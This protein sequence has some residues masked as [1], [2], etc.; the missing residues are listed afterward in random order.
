MPRR[1]FFALI[2]VVVK[3]YFL[4]VFS[5]GFVAGT[6]FA[7]HHNYVLSI[8]IFV[9]QLILL[10]LKRF[11]VI[12]VIVFMCAFAFG[13][14]RFEQVNVQS[15]IH[16]WANKK[17]TVRGMIYAE[18]DVGLDKTRV[19]V[20]I[21]EI[22]L[23][24]EK[25]FPKENILIS[26]GKYSDYRIGDIIE[27]TAKLALPENFENDNG[28]E[29]DYVNFLGKEKIFTVMHQASSHLV[30]RTNKKIIARTLFNFKNYF[31]EHISTILPSPQSELL[32]GL[33]L[34]V[35]KSL[36]QELETAFRRVG[37]IHVVVLS[38]Y[39]ITIIVVAVFSLLA[40][41][42]RFLKYFFG[43]AFVIAF[44][45][46]VGSGAT[47]IRASIMTVVAI[48]GKVSSRE[49]DINRSLIF[50]GLV[51]SIQNP[52]IIFYDPSFQL[53]FLATL[54]LVNLS[55][56]VSSL[57][58]FLPE[59]FGFKEIVSS[60]LSTQIAV[61]PLILKMTGEI[62]VIAL[63]VNLV[64]LPLIPLTMLLGFLAGVLV[65]IWWPLGFIFG[66]LPNLFLS[67]ELWM[68][69]T[70]SL[71]SFA[72]VNF[73][74]PGNFLTILFYCAII[75]LFYYRPVEICKKVIDVIRLAA[76]KIV[77]HE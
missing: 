12:L 51:M 58:F 27:A 71:L 11:S 73:S 41:L 13:C 53:S 21:Q 42:P 63:P 20:S 67:F 25:R 17:V 3:K 68:V 8:L 75:I 36:G 56:K 64:V 66:F 40:F 39:N 59:K 7:L 34:G 1:L 29:F 31:L 37:L 52:L 61:L 22:S 47:V 28:I 9:S 55:E 43:V 38:G 48:L 26:V 74:A 5:A 33:L 77:R 70:F 10:A 32:G 62:S 23:G 65:L 69:E 46:M 45:I 60:T 24:L 44:A 16:D 30:E 72:T 19:K 4:Y 35:K 18:P 6:V 14:F 54:G 76:R 2:K 49:Y 15:E 57:L 50:A